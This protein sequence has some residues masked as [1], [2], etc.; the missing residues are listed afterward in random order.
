MRRF[1]E[2][3]REARAF[4][5]IEF[6]RGVID[7]VIIDHAEWVKTLGGKATANLNT[8]QQQSNHTDEQIRQQ[9]QQNLL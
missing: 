9:Q 7:E 1:T 6:C 5:D 3:M 4:R 8:P 2:N